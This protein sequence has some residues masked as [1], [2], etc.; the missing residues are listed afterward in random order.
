MTQTYGEIYRILGLEESIF[1][2]WQQYPKQSIPV[3][4]PVAFFIELEQKNSQFVWKHKRAWI[5]KAILRKKKGTGGTRLPDFRL[6]YKAT[7]IRTVWY[8]HKTRKHIWTPYLWQRRQEYTMEKRQPLQL[9]DFPWSSACKES[10]CIAG[11][12]VWSLGWEDPLEKE[13]ATPVF[14]PREFH[15]LYIRGV[16][17]SW[18]QLSDFFTFSKQCW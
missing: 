2:K 4:L 12:W 1:W 14:W 7:V 13:T 8:W 9:V 3:K 17:K 18:T 5:A 15:G 6:Y 11:T 16:S 10:A